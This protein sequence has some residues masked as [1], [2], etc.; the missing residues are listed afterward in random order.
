MLPPVSAF[1][2][3]PSLP[4]LPAFRPQY[5]GSRAVTQSSSYSWRRKYIHPTNVRTY[6]SIVT[7]SATRAPS[8]R[9]DPH[10]P[11]NYGFLHVATIT[12]PHGVNGEVKA[13][14]TTDFASH[15]L[16]AKELK[17]YILLPG[18]RYP[19]PIA[20]QAARRAS[21]P[22]VWILRIAEMTTREDFAHLRLQGARLYVRAEDKPPLDRGE[23]VIADLVDL[24]VALRDDSADAY[25]AQTARHGTIGARAPIGIVESVITRHDLCRASG[26]GE[27][28]AAVAND[29]LQIAIFS[30]DDLQDA[31]PFTRTVPDDAKRVLIPFVKQI[32]P[33]VDL[34]AAIVVLDPPPG[35]LSIAVVNKVSKPR[36]PRG[37]LMP[38]CTSVPHQNT[39]MNANEV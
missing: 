29:T 20:V 35:L 32:V 16:S 6:G 5:A 10:A 15:R 25:V 19:R 26:G 7:A 34:S 11:E 37:L 22:D 23:F 8:P 1:L 33:I 3:S 30:H 12:T 27:K 24:R 18:R 21:R 9:T 36:P 38:A 14:A 28:A 39:V 2:Q 31:K 17:R 13:T 4:P